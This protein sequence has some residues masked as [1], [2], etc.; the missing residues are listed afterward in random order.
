MAYKSKSARNAALRARRKRDPIYR[1]KMNARVAKWDRENPD[2]LKIKDL[3]NTG[4]TLEQYTVAE[5]EQ[6]GLCAI[7]GKRPEIRLSADHDHLI[8]ITRQLLCNPC[9][10]MLG[11]A[12]DSVKV[13]E[14]AA[15]YLRKWGKT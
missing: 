14:A 6:E 13:L 10:L 4:W 9:N 15:A 11:N 2:R 8:K 5:K 7:C 12:R 3:K 1:A